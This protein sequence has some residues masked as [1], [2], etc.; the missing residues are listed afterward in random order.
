MSAAS[1]TERKIADEPIA[2]IGMAGR[3]P[4]APDIETFWANLR[5]GTES[6]RLLSEDELLNA[7]V[8]RAQM[9]D[10]N[11]VPV[12]PLL[13]DID[14][15]DAGFFGFSPREASVMDP[16]H[17]IFLE[18]A[19]AAVEQSGYTA[20][21]EEGPVGVFATAGAPLYMSENLHTNPDLMTSMGDFLVR[22][23]GNDMNFL[24]TRVSYEMDLRGP[25]LNIQT[26]C[27]ST[28]V[29]LHMA[30][31][32]L[33]QGECTMALAG[34]ATVL[35][36]AGQGYVYKEGEILSPDGKCRPFDAKSA[37]TV[38]GSG[39]GVVVLKRLSDALDDGDTIHAVIKGSAI[40]NDGAAKVGYLAPGVDGQASV[41]KAALGS[42]GVSADSISYIETH[43]TG[44]LVGD[45]I[46][47]EA[48]NE[49]FRSQTSRR[50]FCAIGSVKSNIG[51]LGEAAA[52]ASLIKA[53]MALKHRQMPPS[54]GYE[55]PNPA[56]DFDNS[57]FYVNDK[58]TNW[59]GTGPLRCG[60]TA[61]GAGG[62]NC[63]V[64]LE[65]APA[66]L[67]GEGERDKQLLV[68]S[69]KSPAALE[70]MRARLAAKLEA[71][72]SLDLADVAYTLAVGRRALPYRCALAASDH[73]DAI[74]R[75][76]HQS[77]KDLANER[78]DDGR[79][80]SIFMFPG[81]GAQYAGMGAELY[82]S[83]P[84]FRDAVNDSL[85]IAN[86]ILGRDLKELIYPKAAEAAAATRKLALPSL[87]LPALFITE[88]AMACLFQSWGLL[89]GA[90]IGHS[91]GEYVAACLAEVITL[92]EALGLVALRGQLFEQIP[93]GAMLS[94][95]LSEAELLSLIPP[96][97]D[98]AAA[99]A[100]DLTVASG[101]VAAIE[102]LEAILAGRD[103]ESTRIH[104]NVAAHSAMLSPILTIF[105]EYCQKIPFQ[106]P[107]I[108]I[109]SNVTGTWM[110]AAQATDPNYWVSHLRST[111]R[112]ANGMETVRSLGT[113][114]LLEVGP[115]RTLSSLARVQ[116]TPFRRVTNSMRHP[117]ETAS[118]LSFALTSLGRM[119][120]GGA[121]IDWSAFYNGQLRNRLALPTYPFERTSFWVTPGKSTS[122]S[123]D[124]EL[125]K[126]S[127]ISDWFY[128]LGFA[129][130]PLIDT[131]RSNEPRRWLVISE[132]KATAAKL[133][134]QLRPDSVTT[135]SAGRSLVRQDAAT[136]QMNFDDPEQ[137]IDALQALEA[138][139]DIPEHLVLVLTDRQKRFGA[140]DNWLARNFLH[141]VYLVQALGSLSKP[142][143][144]SVVT[145]GLCHLAGERIDP[146]RALTLG[147]ILSAPR[148]LDHLTTRC[149]DIGT[150]AGS[151]RELIDELRAEKPDRMIALRGSGRWVRRIFQTPLEPRPE[152]EMPGWIRDDGVYLVTGGLGGIG[153]TIASHLARHKRVRLALLSR[154][155]LPAEQDWDDILAVGAASR[156]AER[157][158][159]VRT[160]RDLGAEVMLPVADVANETALRN[161][162][163]KVR[164]IWGPLTGVIHAA[165]TMD[166]DP[167]MA[168]TTERMLNV[169]APKVAGTRALDAVIDE[170]LDWFIL[171]SS[172][173]SVLGLAGQVDYTAANAFL[174]AFARARSA[175]A[176]GRTLVIN[177]NAWQD[178]G[179]AAA[180]HRDLS[181]S[182]TPAYP[183]RHPA[184]DGFTDLADR[185]IFVRDFDSKR[186]WLLDEHR[187]KNGPALLSG[188]TFVE[189]ARAVIAETRPGY[190]VTLSNVTFLS[191]FHV[192]DGET[193]RLTIEM[194]PS[195]GGYAIAMRSDPTQL[196]HVECEASLHSEP[197]PPALDLAAIGAACNAARFSPVDGFLNQDFMTF[198][199]RWANIR[200][201]RL[202][203][204]Q[205]L[206]ELSLDASF[207]PDMGAGYGLHPALLD[208]ATGGVQTLIP[209]FNPDTDFYVPL[210]YGRV[211]VYGPMPL[212][213]ISHVSCRPES[214]GGLA[215]FDIL[216]SDSNGEICAEIAQFTMKR[217]DAESA[218]A[219]ASKT[220][221]TA[222]TSRQNALAAVLR[223]A[224]KPDEGLQ[225]LDRIMAQ[226]RLIQVVAS[227]V[228]VALWGRQLEAEAVARGEQHRGLNGF[229]R[230][231]LAT[232]FAPPESVLE[233]AL[234]KMW[235]ALLG[236]QYVGVNDSFFDLGGN[237]L[238]AVR[239]FA[240]I[241]R[242][243]AIS[244]PLATLFEAST[245]AD[246]KQLLTER[247]ARDETTPANEYT[248][249][250]EQVARPIGPNWSPI[251][252]IKA[253][254]ADRTPLFCVHGAGG[255][256]MNFR[257]LAQS[258]PAD[259]PFYA[260]QAQGIDG[261]L[262]F[263]ESIDEMATSY[264]E[265]ICKVWPAGPYRLAGYSG[266]GMVA[267]EMAQ[268]LRRSGHEVELLVMFDS[269]APAETHKPVTM[270]EKLH[271]IR[272]MEFKNLVQF[273]AQRFMGWVHERRIDRAR[274][275][276]GDTR[277]DH[278]E[279]VSANAMDAFW[280]SQQ[281]YE[282]DFFVGDIVLYRA[283]KTGALFHRAG[284][285]LGWNK[286]VRGAIDVIHLDAWH[287]T[288][289]QSPSLEPLATDLSRRINQLDAK[290]VRP[291]EIVRQRA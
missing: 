225:A 163:A 87:T 277:I 235:C 38:F 267:L 211:T 249:R 50:A 52:A 122:R 121:S 201:V 272:E 65:E 110:T 228:D 213:L 111:V 64:I 289:F 136:F 127:D 9:A 82:N 114:T 207:A 41:I 105:R 282:P 172:V 193:R 1:K 179:M 3:F 103:I 192:P 218:F 164:A 86:R 217:L 10:P 231:D 206:L 266:G 273:P 8:S 33:R 180:S 248:A 32:S 181:G 140:K 232:T 185:R 222:E 221:S 81:G 24:A 229:E 124:E 159:Q 234:A 7:G 148:E 262:P 243:F 214:G 261:E 160:L 260:L 238:V 188:T 69:A 57:P 263:H 279:I 40:N 146:F 56:I 177:W 55:T 257:P 66:A 253:G 255:N 246:L 175:R 27:S 18:L 95:P 99:N 45:P 30:C 209:G 285:T 208:M 120:A 158:R 118:D 119:W 173:A 271:A 20:L 212:K 147:P 23:T 47:V 138:T 132:N 275:G 216:L 77:G 137:Y 61:L 233:K 22:H 220:R 151:G 76:R 287:D 288:L 35:I 280:R 199:R 6:I 239:L 100:P 36:P 162:M 84:V 254:A 98:I 97:V 15:F 236:L 106:P 178:I 258:L 226:P 283:I 202:G 165:G 152:G 135:V 245:I 107:K 109:V 130:V 123:A 223:E 102:K 2:I 276:Q 4:G 37:G 219:V 252:R 196:A 83:E 155:G 26:A 58:L 104:I 128:G 250:P 39:A 237:S 78:A 284:P 80:T 145:T 42:A 230:P 256:V 90:L 113:V 48:L 131:P 5:D 91:M 143:Q 278:L 205:A 169:L 49:A 71:N 189:L 156:T 21:P 290:E 67:P 184:L 117:Q 241:K 183:S 286:V 94:V 227:S 270:R 265:A 171:I 168:K 281:R 134:R 204:S 170:P 197:R 247:G 154:E 72:P 203:T 191:P 150:G 14:K 187:V 75:L 51:H 70:Q 200:D 269:L 101:P 240:A 198:G 19:W 251:V 93:P 54:L 112:F 153:F 167:V 12:A 116:A 53:I 17:R 11:Y 34:G 89:P 166:D 28:L 62:T 129:D 291:P 274:A 115:G 157:I 161:A 174:D 85:V 74:A 176:R 242:E 210:A 44:T 195:G 68:L 60:I 92:E 224:I 194:T 139:G 13:D 149:I 144:F 79:P 73:R 182:A 63:H 244:L 142:V 264:L 108:P 268:R 88:Y 31:Q 125:S 259:L 59:T 141:P 43:G 186:D 96:G 25:S 16:A 215:Y 133:A 190:A 126:R 46:E 29:A